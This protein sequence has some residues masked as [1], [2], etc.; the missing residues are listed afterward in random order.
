MVANPQPVEASFLGVGL[1]TVAYGTIASPTNYIPV[2]T[3]TPTDKLLLLTDEGW[4]GAP[5]KTYGHT[6]GPLYAEY[7]FGGDVLADVIG[8]PVAG[9]LGD[10]VYSGTA[11]SPTGTL[12]SGASAGATSVSSSVSIPNGTRIQIDTGV[13]S[14]V[15]TTNGAP[16]GAGPY[17]IP[18]PAL[19][20]SHL[21]GV[22]IT[23]IIA[24]Y[25]S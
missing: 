19:K 18:V 10:V 15:V 14:E 21:S 22:A 1:E 17:T 3:L 6:P 2:K 12:S 5:V 4:R 20:Y 23:A 7:E 25:T 9:V 8:F 13:N 11:T 16:S 24:P